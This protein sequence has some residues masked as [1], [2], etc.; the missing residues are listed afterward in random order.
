MRRI[1]CGLAAQAL[2]LIGCC[3][4]G[5]HGWTQPPIPH[6][7]GWVTSNRRHSQMT[8]R[9]LGAWNFGGAVTSTIESTAAV[10]SMKEQQSVTVTIP[11][12]TR[13]D[14]ELLAL[15][16]G[17][18]NTLIVGDFNMAHA[19]MRTCV[20]TACH[21]LGVRMWTIVGKDK[22]FLIYPPGK[23]PQ[24][25]FSAELGKGKD[26]AMVH[27]NHWAATFSL[28]HRFVLGLCRSQLHRWPA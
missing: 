5:C 3:A 13:V 12:G 23:F 10:A 27:I 1:N 21:Q 17:H 20:K 6:G 9:E 18:D 25:V 26:L 15:A 28:H 8:T 16:A 2:L 4:F 22:D 24:G 14:G 11:T 7:L 19:R